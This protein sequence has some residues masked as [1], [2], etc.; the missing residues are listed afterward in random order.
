GSG[1]S[2]LAAQHAPAVP[3]AQRAGVGGALSRDRRDTA[4][5][6]GSPLYGGRPPGP[7]HAVLAAGRAAC[8]RA[9]SKSGSDRPH[10]QGTGGAQTP[11]GHARAQQD[12][13]AL[14]DHARRGADRDERR[15]L[16]AG[17]T[18]PYAGTLALTTGRTTDPATYGLARARRV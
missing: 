7:G 4:R 18:G 9:L 5:T 11:P 10:H 17:G 16:P 14:A 1:V 8:H 2:V 6:P 13:A 3:P 12:R 15:C